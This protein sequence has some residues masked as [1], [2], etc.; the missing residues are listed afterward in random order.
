MR[1]RAWYKSPS[2]DDLHN[3]WENKL[4]KA[5]NITMGEFSSFP[6]G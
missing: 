1:E 2:I 5:K 3:L 4:S 6:K